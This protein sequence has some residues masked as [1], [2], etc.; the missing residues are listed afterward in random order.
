V[1]FRGETSAVTA[2]GS[3]GC[4]LRRGPTPGRMT[5]IE[6]CGHDGHPFR[7]RR[8]GNEADTRPESGDQTIGVAP[9]SS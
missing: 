5:R 1:I 6:V 3:R 4:V 9:E 7:R 2:L 8:S